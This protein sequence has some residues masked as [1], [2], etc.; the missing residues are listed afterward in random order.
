MEEIVLVPITQFARL[1]PTPRQCPAWI[2]PKISPLLY[3]YRLWHYHRGPRLAAQ[4]K[5]NDASSSRLITLIK[6]RST[7]SIV[8]LARCITPVHSLSARTPTDVRDSYRSEHHAATALSA[9]SPPG[10]MP[11]IRIHS[12][13][14]CLLCSMH[15]K[16]HSIPSPSN[17][18][19]PLTPG[20]IFPRIMHSD[21]AKPIHTTRVCTNA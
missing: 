16:P 17:A 9:P 4:S 13:L 18:P 21:L 5:Q 15:C 19:D 10:R 12:R 7:P 14:A 20:L 2:K 8:F 1:V 3:P 11:I 6:L